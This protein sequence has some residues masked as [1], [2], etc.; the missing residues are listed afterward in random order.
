MFSL[1]NRI[2]S[3]STAELAD[4]LKDRPNLLDVRTPTEYRSGHIS[5]ATNWP[6]A[7]VAQYHRPA[8]EPLYVICQSGHRSKQAAKIL[9]TNG[10]QVINVRGGMNAWA[11]KI[12][13]GK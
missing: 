4:R 3:I 8:T 7:K 11:G 13:V 6:L 2:P 1:F 5:I 12:R 9:R 10:Y